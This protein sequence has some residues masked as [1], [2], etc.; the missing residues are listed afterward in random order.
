MVLTRTKGS[1]TLASSEGGRKLDSGGIH[2]ATRFRPM[3]RLL[4]TLLLLLATASASA[5]TRESTGTTPGGAAFKI[6]VPDGWQPGG[7]LVIVNHGYNFE[8]DDSPG[9]SVLSPLLLAQGYA[10]AASG[11][12]DRGWAVFTA[13]DDNV[14]LVE[15][16]TTEFGAPGSLIAVGGS[17]GGVVTL[18][19]LDDPRIS[20]LSGA[21]A[22][23]APADV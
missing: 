10:M 23:C 9:L 8:V 18:K 21:Y 17:M 2:T 5:A 13:L 1:V 7:P 11:Y 14:E 4:L 20:K 19:M 6:A 3:T 15:R 12:R 16:F 22:L